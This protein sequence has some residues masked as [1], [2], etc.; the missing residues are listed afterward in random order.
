MPLPNLLGREHSANRPC[1]LSSAASGRCDLRAFSRWK[2]EDTGYLSLQ[3]HYLP[4]QAH[5]HPLPLIWGMMEAGQQ[6]GQVG[7]PTATHERLGF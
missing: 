6:A 7:M 2:V 1:A 5:R 3:P 4:E